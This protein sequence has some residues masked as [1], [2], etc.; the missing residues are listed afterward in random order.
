[1]SGKYQWLVDNDLFTGASR[2]GYC[3]YEW[4]R[5]SMFTL[6]FYDL[7]NRRDLTRTFDRRSEVLSFADSLKHRKC[8]VLTLRLPDGST[9]GSCEITSMIREMAHGKRHA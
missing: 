6:S 4:M 5:L 1:V 8:L 2:L 9:V 7:Q 3:P